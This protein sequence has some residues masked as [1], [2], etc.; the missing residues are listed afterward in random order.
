VR[1]PTAVK[2]RQQAKDPFQTM[3]ELSHS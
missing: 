2:V 1:R 3:Q